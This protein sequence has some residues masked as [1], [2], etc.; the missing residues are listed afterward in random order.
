MV[1]PVFV[2]SSFTVTLA[3]TSLLFVNVIVV[4]PV[5]PGAMIGVS[6]SPAVFTSVSLSV[7]L[8]SLIVLNKSTVKAFV[9]V[10]LPV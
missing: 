4:V 1:N 7:P 8:E 6:F 9:S 10:S 3:V 2:K 5:V